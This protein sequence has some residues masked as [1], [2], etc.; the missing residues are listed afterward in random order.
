MQNSQSSK[1]KS[2]IQYKPTKLSLIDGNCFPHPT[3]KAVCASGQH[4]TTQSPAS[5]Q[6]SRTEFFHPFPS[7][8]LAACSHH[9]LCISAGMHLVP[10]CSPGKLSNQKH[11]P[12]KKK[13]K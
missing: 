9:F 4:L 2:I 5:S 7:L 13:K 1:Q 10:G 6:L 3:A 11:N 8:L 12:T